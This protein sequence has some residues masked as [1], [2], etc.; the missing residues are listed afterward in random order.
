MS[1]LAE[2]GDQMRDSI[3]EAWAE[4]VR[5]SPMQDDGTADAIRVQST[6]TGVLRTAEQSSVPFAMGR[7]A[8]S[9][10]AGSNTT[11]SPATLKLDRTKYL[12]LD[13]REGDKIRALDRAGQPVFEVASVDSH[14]HHR[15]II[16]LNGA[17]R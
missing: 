17:S 7:D 13:I 5:F 8:A 12:A 9:R 1:V 10:A 2:F 15:L 11:G 4:D 16:N 14:S 6:L 3:D